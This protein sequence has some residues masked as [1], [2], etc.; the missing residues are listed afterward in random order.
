VA[1]E[2]KQQSFEFNEVR[3]LTILNLKDGDST[4]KQLNE[5]QKDRMTELCIVKSEIAT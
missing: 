1:N 3:S 2:E 4:W 5:P